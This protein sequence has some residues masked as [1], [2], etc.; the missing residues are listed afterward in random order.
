M[1]ATE[2]LLHAA[3]IAPENRKAEALRILRGEAMPNAETYRGPEPYLT[4]REIG[5][6]LGISPCSLW[7]WEVPGHDL[8][9]RRRFRLQEVVAYLES[10]DFKRRAEELR[11][12][13]KVARAK[14]RG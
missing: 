6:R 3:L 11:R 4:L 8:G 13:R 7:R 12:N 10:D 14:G 9:G 1:S 5:R 2:E